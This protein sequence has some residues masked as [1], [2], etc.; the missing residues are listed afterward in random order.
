MR[1]KKN[2][3][4]FCSKSFT[5]LTSLNTHMCVKKQRHQDS[6]HVGPRLGF[7]S[8]QRFFELTSKSIKQKSLEEFI[9]SPFY[10]DFVKFG[11]HLDNLRPLYLEKYIDFVITNGV[12]LKDWT[13]DFVYDLYIENL[14]KTEPP[15]TAIERSIST[16]IEWSEKN[17]TVFNKFFY[18][19]SANESIFL[20]KTGKIS[21][22]V[23]YLSSTGGELLEKF[24][25]EHGKLLGDIIDPGFWMKKFKKTD[26][27]EYYRN[28]LEQAEL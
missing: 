27:I 23:L 15:N 19:V 3:C 12:K 24:N 10:I 9:D 7:R 14:I 21:P 6:N 13:K 22:W 1:T 8:F 2:L 20:I 16:I 26:D 11:N 5:Q 25:D 17:N 4:K 18:N 28:L